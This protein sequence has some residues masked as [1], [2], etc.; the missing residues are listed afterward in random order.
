MKASSSKASS[1]S[2]EV[3]MIGT[4]IVLSGPASWVCKLEY[5]GTRAVLHPI[6]INGR[7]GPR[8][9]PFSSPAMT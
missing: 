2:S 7:K 5:H 3:S 4:A 6:P 9:A 8:Q 1:T